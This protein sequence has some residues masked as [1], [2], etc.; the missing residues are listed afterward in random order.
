[1]S[2]LLIGVLGVL[3]VAA[4][5][6]I[7]KWGRGAFAA[8]RTALVPDHRALYQRPAWGLMAVQSGGL[9]SVRLVIACAPSRSLHRTR[10]SPDAAIRLIRSQ[11]PGQFLDQP[12]VSDLRTGV[13]F[14][15]SSIGS[16][17][18]GYAWVWVTGRLD[19]STYVRLHPTKDGRLVISIMDIL[20]PIAQVAEAMASPAYA[21]VFSSPRWPFH[22]HFDW[23]IGVGGD[24]VRDDGATVPW[25]DL[26]FPGRRPQRASAEQY[27]YCP[28]AGFAKDQLR[29]WSPRRP[30]SDLLRAFLEDFLLT[31][32]YHDVDSAITDILQAFATSDRLPAAAPSAEITE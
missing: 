30:I 32:G 23:F 16:T 3:A 10:F 19:L 5:G 2:N 8:I 28:P 15:V 21:E 4:M 13:K 11:F 25:G 29:N 24:L 6:A 12:A 27:P 18:D 17:Q 26:G 20:R 9:N 1:V 31:N 14:T 22:R 7:L